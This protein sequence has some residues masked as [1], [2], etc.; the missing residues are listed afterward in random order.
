[1]RVVP[2][3]LGDRSYGVTI[4]GGGPEPVGEALV[5]VLG[6]RRVAVITDRMVGPLYADS[7]MGALAAAGCEAGLFTMDVGEE[8]KTVRTASAAW[9]WLLEGGYDRSAVVLA[10]GG[11]VVGDMAGFVAATWMRGVDF[12]QC[13]TAP[14]AG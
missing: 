1:M 3:S 2:V 12:V 13:P 6:P 14:G 8:A 4:S 10:L 9:A 7:V 11:G 5:G